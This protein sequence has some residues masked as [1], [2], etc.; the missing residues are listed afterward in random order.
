[1][2]LSV[3]KG[4]LTRLKGLNRLGADPRVSEIYQDSDG[5]WLYT[6]DGW[7]AEPGGSHTIHENTVREVIRAA[8][9]ICKC[10]CEE[11]ITNLGE[12]R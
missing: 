2:A 6:M 4:N 5:I 12:G 8:G 11:C 3:R 7:K 1:M 9:L 10:D